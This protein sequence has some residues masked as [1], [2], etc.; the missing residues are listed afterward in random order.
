LGLVVAW[1]AGAR[2]GWLNAI[3]FPAPS[4]LVGSA[5]AMIRSGELPLNLGVTIT[6]TLEGSAIG[7]L[8]GIVCGILMGSQ[9]AL[10]QALEPMVAAL[11]SIPKLALL[12]LL[13]LFLGI[14]ETPRLLLIASAAFV[15]AT[16]PMLD[17][18]RNLDSNYLELARSYGA[19]SW[20]LV[21]WV[22]VPGCLP[23][24]LTGVRLALSRALGICI[25]IEVVNAQ[26][27]LGQM[28]WAGWLTLTPER[29]YVGV[30]AAGAL[31]AFFHGSIRLLEKTLVPW[32]A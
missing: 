9:R 17:A 30:F 4:A 5:F 19:R 32:K 6:R 8:A 16:L 11:N 18:V 14:G 27:G 20:H 13:M 24:L 2:A 12:P 29:V 3:F 25:A 10:R 23:H 28:I 26:T 21:R 22:Y 15:T 7:I 1:E 31:G